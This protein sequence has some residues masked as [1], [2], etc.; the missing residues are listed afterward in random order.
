M[1]QTIYDFKSCNFE[2]VWVSW[3]R[4]GLMNARCWKEMCNE[5]EKDVEK[6]SKQRMQ[7]DIDNPFKNYR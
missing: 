1:E 3:Q 7:N 2:L 5:I 4:H 6:D